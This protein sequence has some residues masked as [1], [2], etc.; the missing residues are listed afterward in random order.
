[1][2]EWRDRAVPGG[3]IVDII[4]RR[5]TARA[6][7]VLH[8]DARSARDMLAEVAR[9][10]TRLSIVAAA[11]AGADDERYLPAGVE[12]RNRLRRGSSCG[13]EHGSREQKR[14]TVHRRSNLS[15]PALSRHVGVP[16]GW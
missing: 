9:H 16:Q 12:L 7:H 8:D 10:Q 3:G 1:M 15:M 4:G 11:R 14:D 2:L 6:R 5:E 13:E